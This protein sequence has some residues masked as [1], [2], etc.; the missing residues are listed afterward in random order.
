MS[1]QKNHLTTLYYS[2]VY[3]YVTYGILLWWATYHVHMSKLI[4]TQKKTSRTIAGAKY[5][6]RSELLFKSLLKL[7][8]I[9]RLHAGKFALSYI[10]HSLPLSL[11]QLLTLTHAI[12]NHETRHSSNYKMTILIMRT[13]VASNS[14]LLKCLQLWNNIS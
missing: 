11:A 1:Y 14:I 7:E 8:D 6:A 13:V 4:I 9:H 10:K 3:P 5:N 12:H 2:L